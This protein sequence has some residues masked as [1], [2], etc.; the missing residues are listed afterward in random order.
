VKDQIV[1]KMMSVRG[2]V[3]LA[4][5]DKSLIGKA[6]RQD[7]L[8]IEVNESFYGEVRVSEETFVSALGI[9]TIA[10]LVGKIVVGIAIREGFV[11]PDNVITISG[12]PH[13]QYAQMRV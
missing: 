3:L 1:M 12:V 11:D 9:C 8:H 10:N 4:A 6:F 5:A 13:A 7:R 2:E